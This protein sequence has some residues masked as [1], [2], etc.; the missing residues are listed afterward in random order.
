[1]NILHKKKCIHCKS[2]EA[3]IKTARSDKTQ[4]YM[5]R[6]C[7]TERARKYRET[8]NGRERIYAAL[9]RS[10]AKHRHKQD[11]REML[12][13]FLKC[14]KIERLSCKVCGETKTQAHHIDYNIPLLVIWLCR[15]CHWNLH[16]EI[17]DRL[18]ISVK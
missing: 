2:N 4:Y 16:R 15:S 5:C 12:N 13:K 10:L 7:N 17:K 1:M 8:P 11:A 9:R 6:N 3:T 14:K 18:L